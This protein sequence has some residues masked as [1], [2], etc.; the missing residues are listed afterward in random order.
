MMLPL[1]VAVMPASTKMEPAPVLIDSTLSSLVPLPVNWMSPEV[2]L[3]VTP[4]PLR[5]TPGPRINEL[6]SLE[7]VSV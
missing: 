6:M 5:T 4:G 2:T 1:M 3:S 7:V